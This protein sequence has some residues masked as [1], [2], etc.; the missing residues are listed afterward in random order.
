MAVGECLAAQK[1]GQP[2][3]VHDLGSSA[4]CEC[5]YSAPMLIWLQLDP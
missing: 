5:Y 2:F 1:L 3:A 4:L